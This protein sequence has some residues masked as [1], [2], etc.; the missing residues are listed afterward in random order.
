MSNSLELQLAVALQRFNTLQRRWDN[1]GGKSDSLASRALNELEKALEEVRVAQEQ[2]IETRTRLED[3]QLELTQ[4]LEKYWQLFDEM[5]Q[6]YVVTQPDT[7]ILEANQA[8]AEL[9]NVSQRFLVGKT[10]SVF[11]CENRSSF[12]RD[13]AEASQTA[14]GRE[15]T[16]RMRPRERAPLEVTAKLRGG[17]TLRWILEPHRVNTVAA[18]ADV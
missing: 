11:V 12:L 5:P 9:F 2:L 13:A 8:A 17:E 10:L 15:L 1:D 16:L 14:N 18:A 7:V 3:V 4:Q 6:A